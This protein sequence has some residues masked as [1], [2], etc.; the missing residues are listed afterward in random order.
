MRR[1][2]AGLIAVLSLTLGIAVAHAEPGGPSGGAGNPMM[3]GVP[4]VGTIVSTDASAG[5]FTA[6]AFVP[7]L[8]PWR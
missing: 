4:V 6:N 8:R 5:T 3:I 1:A 7:Y 2:I